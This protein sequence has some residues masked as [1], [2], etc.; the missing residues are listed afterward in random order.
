MR[1]DRCLPVVVAVVLALTV[2]GWHAPTGAA[3]GNAVIYE[4]E[5]AATALTWQSV[6]DGTVRPQ[7]P[8]ARYLQETGLPDLPR[9]RAAQTTEATAL[10]ARLAS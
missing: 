3:D 7:L 1:V 2:V 4:G 9:A 6:P 8:G 10:R 5:L